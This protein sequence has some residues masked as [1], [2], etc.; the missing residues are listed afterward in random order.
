[1]ISFLYSINEFLENITGKSV[2]EAI[3]LAQQEIYAAEQKTTGGRKGA[4]AARAAGCDR[5][6]SD[7]K[8]FIFFL[9]NGIKPYGVSNEV[10]MLFLQTAGTLV[11]IDKDRLKKIRDGLGNI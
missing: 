1:M 9:S 2:Q 3:A 5:Y 4:P 7:I 11:G 8:G 6:T 10:F